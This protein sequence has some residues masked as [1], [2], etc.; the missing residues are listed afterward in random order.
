MSPRFVDPIGDPSGRTADLP[1]S[2]SSIR[3]LLE[4]DQGFCNNSDAIA[5]AIASL[6]TS[7]IVIAGPLSPDDANSPGLLPHLVDLTAGGTIALSA[8]LASCFFTRRFHRWQSD[9]NT[10]K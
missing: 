10:S 9:S 7:D 6:R 1:Q 5:T 3:R 4:H 8:H 2:V